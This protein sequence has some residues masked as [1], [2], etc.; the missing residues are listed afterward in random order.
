MKAADILKEL[1]DIHVPPTGPADHAGWAQWPFWAFGI[2]LLLILVLR[3]WR[4]GTW[5]RQGRAALRKID[6]QA[7]A[8]RWT[9]MIGLLRRVARKRGGTSPPAAVFRRPET[10][11][12][13]DIA[14]L[15]EHL[16]R[17][18]SR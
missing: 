3:W 11:D 1:R 2:A 6:H 9:E 5:A 13:A 4:A 17:R 15:R 7:D 18:F 12:K 10:A 8:G 14:A 16:S